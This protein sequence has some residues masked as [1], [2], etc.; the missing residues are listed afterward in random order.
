ML[1]VLYIFILE[2]QGG[3]FSYAPEAKGDA[4]GI[5]TPLLLSDLKINCRVSRHFR[6][7]TTLA[8]VAT[9]VSS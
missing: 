9:S 5:G 7:R 2:K 4:S 1:R 8:K 3:R 6:A